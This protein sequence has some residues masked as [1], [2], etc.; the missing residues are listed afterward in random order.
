MIKMVDSDLL[1]RILVE[2]GPVVDGEVI[3]GRALP[4]E[5]EL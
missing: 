4:A 5:T 1:I 3:G 2:P